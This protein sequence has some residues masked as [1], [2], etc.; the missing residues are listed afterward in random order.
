MSFSVT[1]PAVVTGV[2][3]LVSVLAGVGVLVD[4]TSDTPAP[5][6]PAAASSSVVATTTENP[7]PAP[8]GCVMFCTDAGLGRSEVGKAPV[9]PPA[10]EGCRLFCELER[11]PQ[12]WGFVR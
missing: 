8:P 6:V 2:S 12:G 11:G 7:A 4:Q 3:A 10:P 5:L 1:V 9:S